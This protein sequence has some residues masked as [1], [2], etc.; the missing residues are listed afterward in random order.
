MAHV[1]RPR[2]RRVGHRLSGVVQ[3]GG[4]RIALRYDSRFE[5]EIWVELVGG[6]AACYLTLSGRCIDAAEALRIGLVAEVVPAA[7]L[8]DTVGRL[9]RDIARGPREA[10]I[11][12]KAKTVRRMGS[13]ERVSVGV[14]AEPTRVHET[15]QMISLGEYVI[16]AELPRRGRFG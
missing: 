15:G 6:A 16:A 9:A 1:H 14:V 2:R 13:L 7:E 8:M 12:T 5:A 10:L 3:G 11:P 4:R